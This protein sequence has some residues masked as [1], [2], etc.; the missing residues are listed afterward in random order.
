M[1]VLMY[2][3]L[4]PSTDQ[5]ERMAAYWSVWERRKRDL[6]SAMDA[7]RTA[8]GRLPACLELPLPLLARISTIAG[9]TR[10]TA[11]ARER[12][13][14]ETGGGA[15]AC[16]GGAPPRLLG[17]CV[18]ATR[19]AQEALEMLW[20][21]HVADADLYADTMDLQVQP[22]LILGLVQTARVFCGHLTHDT[23]PLDFMALCQLAKTQQHRTQMF[24]EPPP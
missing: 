12:L 4:S 24:R 10:R 13:Q 21:V 3:S 7:A 16:C 23:A 6:D 17:G 15:D 18:E 9:A 1:H 19:A 5:R 14:V 2:R 11:P 22:M 8:L 20:G